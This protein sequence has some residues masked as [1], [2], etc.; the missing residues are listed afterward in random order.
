MRGVEGLDGPSS[1]KLELKMP[2]PTTTSTATTG[3]QP[4]LHI[5]VLRDNGASQTY[6]SVDRSKNEIWIVVGNDLQ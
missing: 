1:Y 4:T 2:I 5:H 3:A 6:V